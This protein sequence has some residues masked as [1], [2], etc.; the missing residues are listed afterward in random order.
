[1]SEAESPA[2]QEPDVRVEA[3]ILHILDTKGKRGLVLSK[4]PLPEPKGDDSSIQAAY[5]CRFYL[6]P[7]VFFSRIWVISS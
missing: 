4:C 5:R 1:M 7:F 3:A 2:K 6:D